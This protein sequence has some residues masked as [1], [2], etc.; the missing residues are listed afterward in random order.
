MMS[1]SLR[2][3][4]VASTVAIFGVGC[5]TYSG[6]QSKPQSDAWRSGNV[7][8]AADTWGQ[9]ADKVGKADAVIWHLEAGAAYRASGNI[10]NSSRH[11]EDAGTQIDAFEEQAKH[12]IGLETM[13]VM[14]NPQNLPYQG[15]S[16]DK[17][18]LY[19]YRALNYLA[20]GEVE[21]ARPEIIH[22]YQCQQ[23]AVEENNRR[24]E[25]AQEAGQRD[26]NH[27]QIERAK[28]DPQFNQGVEKVTKDLEG[29]KFYADYVNP[30]TVYL[31]GLY[32]LHTAAGGSDLER[33]RKSLNR[34]REVVG[35]NKFV[36]A[37]IQL[38]EGTGSSPAGLTYVVFE[39]GSGASLDQTRIDIPVY[40][41][42]LPYIGAAV[43]KLAFHK[44]FVSELK[45]KAGEL[46]E[47]TETV[48]NM[49]S[50]IALDFKNEWPVVLTK[51]M[52]ST[53]AKSVA[54]AVAIEAAKR[55]AGPLV[56]VLVKGIVM[57]Y[58]AAVNI[59]DTR[60]WTTLPKEFQVARVPT[61]AD[62]KLVLTTPGNSPVDVTV[63]DGTVNVVYVKSVSANSPLTITQFKLK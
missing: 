63:A 48:A 41:S 19:T 54:A 53:A 38:A 12:K 40:I 3:L 4:V 52:I 15:R 58:Q 27:A 50:I 9:K 57:T 31:D 21:K 35:H 39:T 60:S 47:R 46:E 26:K 16:Y 43:P 34:V 2:S 36:E 13:G 25:A 32:Y 7:C 62:R 55:K 37:D 42:D 8:G 6:G 18:M 23:D 51:A 28:S 10:T 1:Q 24:I 61:P 30:F 14:T 56:V 49:D 17:I 11:F 59:A 44:D 29:F 33:A 22:A 5:Q 20:I 45:V